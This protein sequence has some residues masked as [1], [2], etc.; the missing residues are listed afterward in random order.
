MPVVDA[1]A[2]GAFVEIGAKDKLK[3][4]LQAASDR[5]NSWAKSTAKIGTWL[6]AA[7]AAIT[8]PML[9]ALESWAQGGKALGLVGERTGMTV[10]MLSQL[11]PSLDDCGT[12]MET[13]E[14]S[15]G[16]MQLNLSEAASGGKEARAAFAALG[17]SVA[18]L[19]GMDTDERFLAV[20]DAISQIPDQATKAAAAVAVFG[21]SGREMLPLLNL[22]AEGIGAQR[23]RN[24]WLVG[25]ATG[26]SV[27]KASAL[28]DAWDHLKDVLAKLP[29]QAVASMAEDMTKL[30]EVGI[31]AAV[32]VRNW[33]KDHQELFRT[34]YRVGSA[35]GIAGAAILSFAGA[36][37]V[38]SMVSK[39]LHLAT[40]GKGLAGALVSPVGLATVA[41][42]AGVAAW[43]LWTDSGQRATAAVIDAFR[44]VGQT[45]QDTI[46][47][48]Q[49]ALAAGDLALAAKIGF[50]GVQIAILQIAQSLEEVFPS[51]FGSAGD[52]FKNLVADTLQGNWSAVLADME[53]MWAK[54]SEAVVG[55][56]ISAAK[57]IGDWWQ[58]TTTNIANWLLEASA[59][60]GAKGWVASQILG[61][62]LAEV[63]KEAQA[64][65]GT[66]GAIGATGLGV[67]LSKEEIAAGANVAVLEDAK[68]M[69]AEE[70]AGMRKPFDDY[71]KAV[72]D[73]QTAKTKTDVEAAKARAQAARDK[74]GTLGFGDLLDKLAKAQEA[75]RAEA[76]AKRAAIPGAGPEL[77]PPTDEEMGRRAAQAV[78]AG[79]GTFS[80]AALSQMFGGGG[81]GG[82]RIQEQQLAEQKAIRKAS[83][84]QVLLLKTVKPGGIFS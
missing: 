79:T 56:W 29:K 17:L 69:A 66:Y 57:S 63:Q 3:P 1:R 72:A 77:T 52:D 82:Q 53:S 23:A 64:A 16:K 84:D 9:A 37:K 35:L 25:S 60:G 75:L 31:G 20:A 39:T 68:R 48:I 49:D 21:K 44:P 42:V 28:A 2:G 15:V 12:S 76:A 81:I 26:E 27:A 65:S 71:L 58:T 74:A 47:G 43:A 73:Q 62:N 46:G 67:N 10:E 61:V 14:K 38:A 8:A 36:L 80:A 70:L 22:G 7:G 78:G 6:S 45:V 18:D 34:L 30:I 59:A 55:M 32:G 5:L 50:G 54:F 40:I 13:L 4:A 41:L 83:E 51:L 24:Q 33:I 11:A 19:E